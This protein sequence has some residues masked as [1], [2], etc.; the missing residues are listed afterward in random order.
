[1][2]KMEENMLKKIPRAEVIDTSNQTWP[3][4]S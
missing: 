2:K 3:I 1:M 4:E